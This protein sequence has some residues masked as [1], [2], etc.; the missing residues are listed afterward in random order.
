VP[1]DCSGEEVESLLLALEAYC[2]EGAA[3]AAAAPPAAPHASGPPGSAAGRREFQQQAGQQRGAWGTGT[4]WVAPAAVGGE[5][6]GVKGLVSQ[7]HSSCPKERPVS[8]GSGGA[9]GGARG[10]AA[11]DARSA[12]RGGR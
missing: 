4:R 6:C 12:S 5:A 8:R 10:A 3:G 9:S 11:L 2:P 1:E 7:L